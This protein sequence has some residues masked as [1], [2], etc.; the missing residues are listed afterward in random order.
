MAEYSFSPLF[1]TYFSLTIGYLET[2]KQVEVDIQLSLNNHNYYIATVCEIRFFS[3]SK[4][5]HWIQVCIIDN[6]L[7][8]PC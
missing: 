7:S 5:S 4:Q 6:I 2:N 1:N 3:A 8:V